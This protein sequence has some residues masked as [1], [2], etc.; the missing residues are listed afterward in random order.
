MVGPVALRSLVFDD[1]LAFNAAVG[2]FLAERE[3]VNNLLIGIAGDLVPGARG[4]S[5]LLAVVSNGAHPVAAALMT[6]P[7]ELVLSSSSVPGALTALARDLYGRRIVLPGVEG[8]STEAQVFAAAWSRMTATP[9]RLLRAGQI[10]QATSVIPPAR[11]VPGSLRL[12]GA[13]DADLVAGWITAF[14]QEAVFEAPEPEAARRLAGD[15]VA[16]QVPLDGPIPKR[17]LYLWDD[18][19]PVC[20][21]AAGGPT[22]NGRRV[23][24]VYTPPT[25]RRRGYASACVT[26]VTGLLLG[27]GVRACFLFTDL[28]NPTA[29]HIYQ[30]IGYEPVAPWDTYR[31]GG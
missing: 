9:A 11:P 7:R 19:G 17:G 23:F 6:P 16:G 4:P 29:N 28:S 5:P 24:A 30:A 25:L 22:P 21:A 27:K 13:E 2:D 26:A 3:V 8:P 18:G 20:M 14:N 1:P 12:A 10:Y 15:L 31:F